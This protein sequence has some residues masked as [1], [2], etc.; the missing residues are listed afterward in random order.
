MKVVVRRASLKVAGDAMTRT[1]AAGVIAHVV[2]G[3]VLQG[4]EAL[5]HALH[6]TH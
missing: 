2:G 5:L 4:L 3:F 1:T 6:H